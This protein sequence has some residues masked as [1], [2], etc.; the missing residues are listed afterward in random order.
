MEVVAT[1]THKIKRGLQRH[2]KALVIGTLAGV[3]IYGGVRVHRL[4]RSALDQLNEADQRSL[5]HRKRQEHFNRVSKESSQAL[6]YFISSLNDAIEKQFCDTKTILIEVKTLRASSKTCDV[7]KQKLG[8]CWD[9]LKILSFSK[10]HALF[11]NIVSFNRF[12]SI[13]SI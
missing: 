9:Q 12:Y 1:T 7:S 2:R 11:L 13:F 10:V 3:I 5:R 6:I 8:Q 4:Y